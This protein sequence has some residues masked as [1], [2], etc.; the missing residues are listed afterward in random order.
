M[1]NRSAFVRQMLI[2]IERKEVVSKAM[3]NSLLLEFP[4]QLLI[5]NG[6]YRNSSSIASLSKA[7]HCHLQTL[8]GVDHPSIGPF[9]SQLKKVQKLYDHSHEQYTMGETAPVKRKKYQDADIEI[10]N[11]V[12][13]FSPQKSLIEYLRGLAHSFVMDL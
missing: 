5:P 4:V 9:L 12:R 10:I 1:E 6:L 13:S 2:Q 8:F 7:S 11:L 3:T